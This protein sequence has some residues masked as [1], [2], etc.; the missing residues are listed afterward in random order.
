[1]LHNHPKIEV[2]PNKTDHTI[3]ILGWVI[4]GFHALYIWFSFTKLPE[5]IP[6]HF[7]I[8]GEADGF[9]SK[10]TIWFVLV[11]NIFMY[12]LLA[13]L[14]NKMKPWSFNY[15]TKITVNNAP[16]VY[17]MSI[18][19]I[20]LLNFGIALIFL[21]ISVMIITTAN[22]DPSRMATWL[23]WILIILITFGPLFPIYRM[24]KIPK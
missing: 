21:V 10:N 11:I 9:G 4:I 18:R 16:Q 1:M 17:A 3:L 15:P 20:V 14:A 19:M 6:T 23:F 7:N 12:A 2:R 5:T 24:I 22:Q 13:F 8:N